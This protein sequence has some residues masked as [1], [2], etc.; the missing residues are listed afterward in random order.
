MNETTT[1]ENSMQ[2][3]QNGAAE[4]LKERVEHARDV[5]ENIRDKAELALR[6][7]PYLLPIAAGAVGLGIGVLLGSKLMRF[8]VFTAVGTLLSDTL[9][10]EIKRISRD[11]MENLQERLGAEGEGEPAE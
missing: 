8:I 5:V 4:S 7:K 1:N 9:G 3:R 11:F 2:A 6:D 10:G